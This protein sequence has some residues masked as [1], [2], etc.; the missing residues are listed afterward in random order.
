VCAAEIRSALC[1]FSVSLAAPL[2]GLCGMPRATAQCGCRQALM[3][4][5]RPLHFSCRLEGVLWCLSATPCSLHLWVCWPLHL[6]VA[7][8][9]LKCAGLEFN[10]MAP[11]HS[12]RL[13]CIARM[14]LGWPHP[15]NT[16]E[17]CTGGKSCG[18]AH[19]CV[20]AR[21]AVL[22]RQVLCTRAPRTRLSPFA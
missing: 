9:V 2:C 15:I 8:A 13:S 4:T 3:S 21:C 17:V 10:G 18:M 11:F 16:P 20:I 5:T 7:A 22:F 1:L 12:T 14:L 6:F 19:P